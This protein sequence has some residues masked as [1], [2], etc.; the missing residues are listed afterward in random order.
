MREAARIQGAIEILSAYQPQLGPF[1]QYLTNYFRSRRYMGSGDRRAIGDLCFNVLRRLFFLNYGLE[2]NID[3][4][5]YFIVLRYLIIDKQYTVDQ[6]NEMNQQCKLG[7]GFAPI[8]QAERA[9]L[10]QPHDGSTCSGLPVFLHEA[11]CASYS[12]EQLKVLCEPAPTDIRVNLSKVSRSTVLQQWNKDNI[13]GHETKLS[14]MGIRLQ[15]RHKLAEN[16]QFSI[17]DQ[18][19]QLLCTW[20]NPKPGEQI[21]DYCAGAGGKSLALADLSHDQAI[22]HAYDIDAGKSARL[23]KRVQMAGFQSIILMPDHQAS[24]HYDKVVVDA[25]CSGTG[26]LRRNPER[27]L[28]LTPQ[29]VDDLIKLQLQILAQAAQHVKIGGQLYYF[30][31]SLLECENKSVVQQFLNDHPQ[32]TNIVSENYITAS[33]MAY[34]DL[35]DI[36]VILTPWKTD[37]D[38][39]YCAVLKRVD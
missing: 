16:D 4:Q 14:P 33:H 17:Q 12:I 37:T 36:G 23:Q 10:L 28:W 3:Y 21:L 1:D 2:N 30:T 35:D 7:Y 27:K 34:V 25:P 22:I 13:V 5:Y 32:F 20:V 39:F 24:E 26:V 6:L 38:G 9:I 18:G 29:H 19:S 8:E 11:L 31:C 15:Q